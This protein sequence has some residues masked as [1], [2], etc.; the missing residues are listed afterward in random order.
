[1]YTMYFT[2]RSELVYDVDDNNSCSQKNSKKMELV[3]EQHYYLIIMD[4]HD[5]HV[6]VDIDYPQ[7]GRRSMAQALPIKGIR[8]TFNLMD[9][10]FKC[11]A[12]YINITSLPTS[13]MLACCDYQSRRCTF[14]I[15]L[16]LGAL[17]EDILKQ[18]NPEGVTWLHGKFSIQSANVS[19]LALSDLMRSKL[20][21][22]ETPLKNV[23]P[24]YQW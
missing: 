13:N 14:S 2:E 23:L 18:L 19:Y 10:L 20:T 9:T 12:G 21:H 16:K 6:R 8:R 4:E 15:L 24:V 3:M 11:F 5:V 17:F 1:M 22:S 7:S